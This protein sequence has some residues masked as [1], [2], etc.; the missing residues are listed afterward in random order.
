MG[1][2]TMKSFSKNSFYIISLLLIAC[3]QHK[4]KNRLKFNIVGAKYMLGNPPADSNCLYEANASDNMLTYLFLTDSSLVEI[5]T[6]CCMPLTETYR[7]G[8]Y[9]TQDDKLF[10]KFDNRQ[11]VYTY[12]AKEDTIVKIPESL[13]TEQITIETDT[14]QMNFCADTPYFKF[15]SG[16]WNQEYI[17]KADSTFKDNI[18]EMKL[19]NV[20]QTLFK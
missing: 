2:Q 4:D 10:V 9:K 18:S 8:H 16:Y 20:W 1:P 19:K 15:L 7:I 17:I 3:V 6:A 13:E 11:I 5:H 14:L 12:Q